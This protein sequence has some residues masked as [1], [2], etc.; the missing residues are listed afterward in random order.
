T[1][2]YNADFDGDEMQTHIPQT[3]GAMADVYASVHAR[4][5]MINA[6][7]SRPLFGGVYDV[8]VAT[9]LLSNP[10][11]V[12]SEIHFFNVVTRLKRTEQL[13]TLLPRIKRYGGKISR[14]LISG[15]ELA[16][17]VDLYMDFINSLPADDDRFINIWIA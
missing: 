14:S 5:N 7:S 4:R 15:V 11:T 13:F 6:Q 17:I 9:T 10:D 12:I 16:P 8:P 2:A 1:K 3:T